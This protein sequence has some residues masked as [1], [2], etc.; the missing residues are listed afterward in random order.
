MNYRCSYLKPDKPY[1]LD[2]G[3]L[4]KKGALDFFKKF[5]WNEELKKMNSLPKD[6]VF[7]SPSVKFENL[8]SSK[9]IE[10]SAVGEENNYA[11][12]IFYKR[13][14]KVK[15]FFGLSTKIDDHYITETLDVS[16][17]RA[18]TILN[19]FFDKEWEQLESELKELEGNNQD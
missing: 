14:K 5:N 6:E 8:F 10:V 4:E 3:A 7:F 1:S 15:A 17:E 16:P 11:F 9:W 13:S 19:H 2:K 18:N 12:C